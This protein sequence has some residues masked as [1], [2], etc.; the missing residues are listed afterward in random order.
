MAPPKSV[1]TISQEAFDELVKENIEDLEMDPTEALE[2]AIQTLT[3]QDVDLSGIVSSILGSGEENPV[4]QSLERLKELDRDWK[5]EGRDEK[6]VN[7][8]VEWLDK[9]NAVCNVDAPGNA[10]IASKNGAVELVCSLCGKL[11]SGFN[12]A[13]VSA[14]NTLASL[15]HDLQS[16]EIFRATNGPKLVMNILNN[17]KE[18]LSILNSGFSVVS[19]AATGNEVIKE[20]FMNLKI[21]EL[22]LQCL[23]E[24]SRGS[25]P[26]LY[27]AVRV[28]LT[29]DDNRVVASEV[30]G[31][32]RRFAKIGIVE[33]LVDSLHVWIKAPSLVSA[34]VALKA[35]AVN[36]EI[37]RAVADNGGIAAIL[38]CIDDSGEQGEKIVARTCCSLLSKLAGSDI[39]K[40]A[41]VEKDGMDKL[42][43]LATRF[44]DDPTVLQEVMSTIM[45]LT[46][47]SPHNAACAVEAGAGDIV[48][49][50]MQRFPESE[51]LQRSCCFM[52]RNLVVRNP[53]NRTILLGNGIEKLI[54][55]AKMNCKSCKNAA[56]DALRDLGLDNF[57]L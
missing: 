26:Y 19:A 6:D 10:A 8:I 27:D 25:I 14:L 29:S 5:Q 13:L 45:V 50:A 39:N 43:K 15:L 51:L 30:Y 17:R 4:I 11:G 9:L 16:I 48:I 52:I 41:I 47:R 23:R 57:N 37:C 32:A 33:A 31:Y 49:R 55:K 3:L 36:D 18:N 53:E 28:L 56:A 21:D 42:M 54:R 38:Q 34:T 44:S 20:A 24:F 40:S 2:D 12:Q 7:E 35:I 22:I 46:L 1:R